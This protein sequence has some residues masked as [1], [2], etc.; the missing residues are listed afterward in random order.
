MAPILKSA[1]V[2]QDTRLSQPLRVLLRLTGSKHTL[3]TATSTA[4][5][6]E[7]ARSQSSRRR[8]SRAAALVA[9]KARIPE[10]IAPT[11]VPW[12]GKQQVSGAEGHD[13][14]PFIC[15]LMG[16]SILGA[17]ELW[18]PTLLLTQTV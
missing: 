5:A 1:T 14:R 9:G 8:W 16:G 3:T 15:L 10:Q 6:P 12:A 11:V 13:L 18:E 17:E 4:L 7:D 2:S